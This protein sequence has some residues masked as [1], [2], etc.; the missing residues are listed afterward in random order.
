MMIS[1]GYYFDQV[2]RERLTQRISEQVDLISASTPNA[3]PVSSGDVIWIET[4]HPRVR[5]DGCYMD[6]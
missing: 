1:L 2:S 3:A 4:A 6:G 5:R